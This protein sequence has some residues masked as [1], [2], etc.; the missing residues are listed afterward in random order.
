MAKP[1]TLHCSLRTRAG[2]APA[3]LSIA[4]GLRLSLAG[5]PDVFQGDADSLRSVALDAPATL[6]VGLGPGTAE[7]LRLE[8]GSAAAA[9][10]AADR[11]LHIKFKARAACLTSPVS[12]DMGGA[13]MFNRSLHLRAGRLALCDGPRTLLE[14]LL[15]G[16]PAVAR[17]GV[18]GVSL[19]SLT[20]GFATPSEATLWL[21][22]L[23]LRD[24]CLE[25]LFV[26]NGARPLR[27]RLF[28]N[29]I[30]LTDVRTR[31]LRHIVPLPF[32]GCG[33][34]TAPTKLFVSGVGE[35][36]FASTTQ[37]HRFA[38]LLGVPESTADVSVSLV[39]QNYG[40]IARFSYAEAEYERVLVSDVL[41]RVC[42]VLGAAR[43]EVSLFVGAR[44]IDRAPARRLLA[45]LSN[46][47]TIR[48]RENSCAELTRLALLHVK[49]FKLAQEI[50][51]AQRQLG[52]RA[53]SGSKGSQRGKYYR[54]LEEE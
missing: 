47:G 16:T 1:H 11:L 21:A 35:L 22:A 44:R 28:S 34:V 18:A 31:E 26:Y 9:L 51:E 48:V 10:E 54:E 4:A 17:S 6:L 13:V 41:A 46:G 36:N 29:R 40:E 2:A 15:E 45:F 50:A 14:V 25:E 39:A 23:R 49:R 7:A 27:L 53:L 24:D 8:F 30:A 3:T 12:A 19:G 38:S 33:E 32:T 37:L 42:E 52:A 20:F 43:K 5:G